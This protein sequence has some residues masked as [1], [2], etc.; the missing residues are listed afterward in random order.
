MAVIIDI[1]KIIF[2]PD[3]FPTFI[4]SNFSTEKKLSLFT[5]I[6]LNIELDLFWPNVFFRKFTQLRNYI[7]YL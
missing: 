6:T 7:V 2:K 3:F 1:R 4:N 5:W